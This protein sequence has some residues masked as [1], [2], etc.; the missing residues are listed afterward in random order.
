MSTKANVIIATAGLG[1]RMNSISSDLHKSL[2][3]YKEKPLLYHIINSVPDNLIIGVILGHK[4]T[5]ITDFLTITFPNKEFILINVDD[6]TSNKSGTGYSLKSAYDF[7]DT[8]FWYFTC[9][10]FYYNLDFI[11]NAPS[12]DLYIVS[13]INSNETQNFLTFKIEDNRVVTTYLKSP[14]L[15]DVFAFTG[16][17]RIKDKFEFFQRLNESNSSEFISLI[18]SGALTQLTKNWVDLGN[19][20]NYS[21]AVGQ[22]K[23]DFT[24]PNEFTY[25]LEDTII[26]W[27]SDP[28]IASAKKNK[29]L[30]SPEVFP[31]NASSKGEFFRYDLAPGVPFYQAVTPSNFEILLDWLEE[32]VWIP[33]DLDI[34]SN[35]YEFYKVKTISR[36]DMLG[37]KKNLDSFNPKYVDGQAVLNWKSYFEKIDW[38]LLIN[39]SRSTFIHGDLQ[40]DNIIFDSLSK[41][42]TL[43]DWR[44]DFSGLGVFGDLYYDF[45][46][47]LGGIHQ[48]YQLIKNGELDFKLLGSEA[49]TTVPSSQFKEELVIILENKA[50]SMG[51]NVKKIRLLVPLI[52]WNMSPLHKEPFSN[53]CWCLG[54]KFFEEY[55]K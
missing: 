55:H 28:A 7:V 24:K 44:Y 30:N 14:D 8:S 11:N 38:D 43:I 50:K 23:F 3:P 35:L 26:K 22:S 46:K 32:K 47:L 29:P 45:A 51:L 12:E 1:S 34:K 18:N 21:K 40:F 6:W 20:F 49:I 52:Y 33:V 10:G 19:S 27:W 16:A 13:Q 15:K 41:K 5:Q 4:S 2:L 36:I 54:L 37:D 39:E 9:D 25:Q 31:L 48:N 17:M 53:I 42:F